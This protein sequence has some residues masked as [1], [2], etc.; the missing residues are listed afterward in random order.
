MNAFEFILL[1][2]PSGIQA[3]LANEEPHTVNNKFGGQ[4][5]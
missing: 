1:N 2:G 5:G 3:G 4:Y